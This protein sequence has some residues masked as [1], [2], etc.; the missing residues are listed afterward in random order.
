MISI[1]LKDEVLL[2]DIY[3]KQRNLTIEFQSIDD[4]LLVPCKQIEIK[5]SSWIAEFKL[6]GIL[7]VTLD[8]CM[9]HNADNEICDIQIEAKPE[10]I[11][12]GIVLV[13]I[14]SL[15]NEQ[16]PYFQIPG[17]F[18]GTNNAK[19]S[20]SIQP[21]LN[22]KGDIH[23]PKTPTYFTRT[24]R[25]TH[26]CV[27]SIHD[28]LVTLLNIDESSHYEQDSFFN[29]LGIDTKHHKTDSI[30]V[31]LGF[32]HFPLLYRGKVYAASTSPDRV[33]CGIPFRP[34]IKL[35]TTMRA[36][37]APATSILDYEKALRVMYQRIHVPPQ[38]NQNRHQAVEDLIFA[39][40]EETYDKEFHFFPT[41]HSGLAPNVKDKGDIAWTGGMQV[42]YPLIKAS[43]YSVNAKACALDFIHHLIDTGFNN[44]AQ[45]FFESK[46]KDT[47]L[48]SGWWKKDLHVYTQEG[49]KLDSA[50][51]AYLNGQACYYL[52]KSYQHA[53]NHKWEEGQS[54][55]LT[56]VE[57]ILQRVVQLQRDDGAFPVYFD[58]DNGKPL[59]YASFQGAW[60]LAALA[61]LYSITGSV[62]LKKSIDRAMPFYHSF[63]ARGELWGTPIDT[64]D[65]VDQEGN[66]AC[67]IA[68]KT[69]HET[70]QEQPYLD[71]LLHGLHWEFSFKFAYN[72][73]HVNE[74]LRSL[75]WSSCGGSVT[76]THNI[77]IHPMGCLIVEEIYYAYT[78]TQDEYLLERLKDTLNWSLGAYNNGDE[79]WGYGKRGHTTEQFYH[80]D[81]VQDY[82]DREG[83]GGIWPDFLSWAAS[84]ILFACVAD[85]PQE[86]YDV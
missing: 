1:E 20:K 72:T 44:N 37:F 13:K 26:G 73:R 28:S 70:E 42:A 40:V 75:D 41:V 48:V 51:S 52:L 19:N 46:Y 53:N 29:G 84:C 30:A 35:V 54:K 8:C 39:L 16:I 74:P 22:Y 31:T 12:H 33:L 5:G 59:Y 18:Y 83:E 57:K 78:V 81:G 24:D 23:Y 69:M 17:N 68:M 58:P 43:K 49:K 34:G 11:L 47:W 55:W 25:S 77:H 15:A 9:T 10:T 45:L 38:N 76:S 64:C 14:Q 82:G 86:L 21:Q 80:T 56:I 61:E 6:E 66:L 79:R 50:H 2:L 32:T 63:Y 60:F 71:L 67:V 85:V 27:M 4:V 3:G 62:D 7:S 65:A 36:Y